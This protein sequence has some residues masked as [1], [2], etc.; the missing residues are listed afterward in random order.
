MSSPPPPAERQSERQVTRSGIWYPDGSVVLQAC[1]TQFR[2]HWSVLSLHSSFF[3]GMLGLPPP[4]ETPTVDGCPV[5]ELS[6]DSEE[7]VENLLRALYDPSVPCS[8][9]SAIDHVLL[10]KSVFRLFFLQKALPFPIIASH[11]RL[12]RKYEFRGVLETIVERLTH[13]NPTTLDGYDALKTGNTYSPT[14]IVNYRG[15]IYDTITLAGENNILTVLP[16]AYYRALVGSSPVRLDRVS[17]YST[18]TTQ[19]R[20]SPRFSTAY[21][22]A[23]A[24]SRPYLLPTNARAISAARRSC[25][26]SGTP[27]TP[28]DGLRIRLTRSTVRTRRGAMTVR[29]YKN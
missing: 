22:E 3:H 15:L 10:L 16:C 13:E 28:S 18:P 21:P 25:V 6:L 11:L 9:V 2:V 1:N 4:P 14:R 23:T 29:L 12:S 26:P 7:D 24:P 19:L 20:F 5:V 17:K 8:A 27:K